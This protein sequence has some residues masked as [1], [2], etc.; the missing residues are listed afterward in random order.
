MN[1]ITKK[2][3][4]Q[5]LESGFKGTISWNKYQSKVILSFENNDDRKT[6]KGYFLPKV[7]IKDYNDPKVIQQINFT[8]DLAQD[9]NTTILIC[10]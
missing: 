2:M 6:H 5:K 1:A 10:S 4:L 9:G 8:K 3:L 7:E